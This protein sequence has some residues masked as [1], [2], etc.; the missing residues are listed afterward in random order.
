[1]SRFV[2][3]APGQVISDTAIVPGV[4]AKTLLYRNPHLTN[5]Y[6]Y[7][8]YSMYDYG[9][10]GLNRPYSDSMLGQHFLLLGI[11]RLP[12]QA[13]WAART[14]RTSCGP[15]QRPTITVVR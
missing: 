15:F 8:H 3:L 11:E 1:M 12:D 5:M 9:S 14:I 13:G 6:M 10:L 4:Y 2:A 7:T